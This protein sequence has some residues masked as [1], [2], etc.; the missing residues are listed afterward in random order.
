ME[1]HRRPDRRVVRTKR[2]IRNAFIKLLSQKDL[3]DISVKDI[4]DAADVDRKTVYNYY[5]GVYEIRNEVENEIIG[6][7]ENAVKELDVK[8]S[9]DDPLKLFETLTD[10]INSNLELYGHLFKIDANS[11][12]IRKVNKV[13][14]DKVCDGLKTA[15]LG[16]CDYELCA[17]FVTSG[18]L[19]VY[20]NWFDSGCVKPLEQL[21][22]EAGKLVIDGLHSFKADGA[23]GSNGI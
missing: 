9:I 17:D 4:A 11:Y 13:L 16:D 1:E 19:S 6:L 14:R 10:I 23:D 2:A 21:S 3:N 18:M 22:K 8:S 7:L 12:I 20:Q 15:E 5:S